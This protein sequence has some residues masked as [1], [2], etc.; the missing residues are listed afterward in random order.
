MFI[1]EFPIACL[2]TESFFM[3]VHL[4]QQEPSPY[5]DTQLKFKY[6]IIIPEHLNQQ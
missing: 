3:T 6:K 4:P 5:F 2:F 1:F